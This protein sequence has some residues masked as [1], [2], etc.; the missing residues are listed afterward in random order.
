MPRT[1]LANKNNPR[2]L[3]CG[4]QR[5]KSAHWVALSETVDSRVN[6]PQK[7]FRNALIF[8]R[9]LKQAELQ[10][11]T[12]QN[13]GFDNRKLIR[14]TTFSS[15]SIFF[16]PGQQNWT[17]YHVRLRATSNIHA[18][19]KLGCAL[20]CLRT[21]ISFMSQWCNDHMDKAWVLTIINNSLW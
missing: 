16:F 2:F 1:L 21:I 12:W 3:L 13:P 15:R 14:V 9:L 17:I 8:C 6:M 18:G 10:T 5:V 11:H 7:L 20:W 4:A 19:C